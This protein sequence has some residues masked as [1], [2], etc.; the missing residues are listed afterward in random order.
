M[1]VALH[2]EFNSSAYSCHC[3]YECRRCLRQRGS[4]EDFNWHSMMKLHLVALCIPGSVDSDVDV[5]TSLTICC[6]DLPATAVIKISIEEEEVTP[7]ARLVPAAPRPAL[8][9]LLLQEICWTNGPEQPETKGDSRLPRL[10]T[11]Q[12]TFSPQQDSNPKTHVRYE[13]A[14]TH[15]MARQPD[16]DRGPLSVMQECAN[17]ESSE[18]LIR[19]NE[20]SSTEM[21]MSLTRRSDRTSVMTPR[22]YRYTDNALKRQNIS[23]KMS[24]R[25][26]S[27]FR[28]HY[29]SLDSLHEPFAHGDEYTLETIR[30]V[31]SSY[32][33]L[34]SVEGSV[35]QSPDSA[36][37]SFAPTLTF[38]ESKNESTA[39]VTE[40]TNEISD[41][42]L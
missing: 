27:S 35:V 29:P 1:V 40:V 39:T 34:L 26:N 12:E 24:S 20:R 36:H 13:V 16:K 18:R 41:Q 32:A 4:T 22:R 14:K 10:Q 31:Y 23:H 28:L 17:S 9:P 5:I 3:L 6:E 7:A 11:T 33:P 19:D 37:E 2:S 8:A 15:Q 21:T 30:R 42:I 38:V 25:K